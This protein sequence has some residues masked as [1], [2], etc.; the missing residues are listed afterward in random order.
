MPF[1]SRNACIRLLHRVFSSM[2]VCL[3]LEKASE[4]LDLLLRYVGTG[5]C[6]K[7]EHLGESLGIQF[8]VLG[9]EL[10]KL[11]GVCNLDVITVSEKTLV[12]GV[13]AGAGF[14]PY[15]GG[16]KIWFQSRF[17]L[18]ITCRYF[19]LGENSSQ[20]ISYAVRCFLLMDI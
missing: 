19:R 15:H 7:L 10:A 18:R 9:D 3:Y 5:E 2:R 14:Q 13:V 11:N 8:V 6:P 1:L 16:S 17:K 12:E 4:A 20:S